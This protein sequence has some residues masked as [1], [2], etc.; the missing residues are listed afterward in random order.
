MDIYTGS[1]IQAQTLKKVEQE[2]GHKLTENELKVF[3]K[4]TRIAMIKGYD[5]AKK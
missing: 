1:K 4:A 3:Y 2:L 5:Y